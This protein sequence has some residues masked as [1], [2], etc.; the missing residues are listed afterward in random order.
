MC[1]SRRAVAPWHSATCELMRC[2]FSPR[3][4]PIEAWLCDQGIDPQPTQ[5]IRGGGTSSGF[6]FDVLASLALIA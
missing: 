6:C 2:P 4:S 5:T 1:K 3:L